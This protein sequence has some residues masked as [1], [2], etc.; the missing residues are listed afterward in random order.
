LSPATAPEDF[1]PAHS[2]RSL[3]TDLLLPFF[4][5][6]NKLRTPLQ[7]HLF[8]EDTEP[9]SA[10][11]NPAAANHSASPLMNIDAAQQSASKLSPYQPLIAAMQ[12]SAPKLH[13]REPMPA[14]VA[15]RAPRTEAA[16]RSQP[17]QHEPDEVHIHIGRI[18]VA[19]IPQ[20]VARPAAAAARRS[21]NLSD[22]LARNGR[23]G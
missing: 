11:S 18:E 20:Q 8:S 14:S 13:P 17:A 22:Y 21:I 10:T 15:I 12:Q 3:N 1:S 2:S 7:A 6:P 5:S 19:A 9:A 23:P 16:R 4:N